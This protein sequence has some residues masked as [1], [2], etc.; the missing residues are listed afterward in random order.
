MKGK[1]IA[2]ALIALA[3]AA[4]ACNAPED[5]TLPTSAPT[6]TP[7]QPSSG[8]ETTTAPTQEATPSTETPTP[9]LGATQTP[10]PTMTATPRP[11]PTN[12]PVPVSTGPLDFQGPIMLGWQALASGDVEVTLQISIQGGAPPFTIHHDVEVFVTSERDYIFT[13][14]RS[15]CSPIVHTAVV[16]SADGQS[17][18]HDYF[19]AAS[20]CD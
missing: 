3:L 13:L 15:G 14:Q 10:T 4:L 6:V 12:T 1:P 19:I 7:Y 20:W 16:E 2:I 9:T 11:L 17:V 5:G 8:E 18:S